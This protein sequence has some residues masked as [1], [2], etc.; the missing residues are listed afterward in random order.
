M[1]ILEVKSDQLLEQQPSFFM[2]CLDS[3]WSKLDNS[4][5]LFGSTAEYQLAI[6]LSAYNCY[7]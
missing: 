1:E 3:G 5:R 2:A 4:C 6:V 7:E